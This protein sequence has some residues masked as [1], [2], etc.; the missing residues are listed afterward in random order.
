MSDNPAKFS[1][2]DTA[3]VMTALRKVGPHNEPVTGVVVLANDMWIRVI[4]Y[5]H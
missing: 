4:I 2:G 1:R 5:G 3:F